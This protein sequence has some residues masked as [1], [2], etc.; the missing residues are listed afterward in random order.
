M[1]QTEK[2]FIDWIDGQLNEEIPEQIKLLRH[3]T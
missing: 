2:D 1:I 3:P